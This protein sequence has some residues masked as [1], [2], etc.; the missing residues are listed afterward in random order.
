M[1]DLPIFNKMKT[2]FTKRA[3]LN[4]LYINEDCLSFQNF[5]LL[6][7]GVTKYVIVNDGFRRDSL[8]KTEGNVT[9]FG[10]LSLCVS[11]IR[12]NCYHEFFKTGWFDQIKTRA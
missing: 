12:Q 10:R 5:V 3:L 2:I 9:S 8:F 1:A 11:P 4:Y 6:Q 7:C